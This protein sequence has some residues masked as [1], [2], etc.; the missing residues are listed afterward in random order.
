MSEQML[1]NAPK[2]EEAKPESSKEGPKKLSE[3][4]SLKFEIVNLNHQ[5]LRLKRDLLDTQEALV[6]SQ[7]EVLAANEAQQNSARAG[8]L[9]AIGMDKKGKVSFTKSPDGLY[10]VSFEPGVET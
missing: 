8:L 10:E 5:I 3:V 4:E 6:A 2:P 1:K 7:R 9:K